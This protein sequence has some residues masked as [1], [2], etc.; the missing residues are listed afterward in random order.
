MFNLHFEELKLQILYRTIILSNQNHNSHH[1][2]LEGLMVIEIWRSKDTAA[3]FLI[4][5]RG[6]N[7]CIVPIRT[8]SHFGT[9][10]TKVAIGQT[11]V[12]V[13]TET[14]QKKE[15]ERERERDSSILTFSG[16]GLGPKFL[17][18]AKERAISFSFYPDSR[19]FPIERR[20]KRDFEFLEIL[21]FV[22]PSFSVRA[23]QPGNE[24][25]SEIHFER[26]PK[27]ATTVPARKKVFPRGLFVSPAKLD[28]S[29]F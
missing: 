25:R 5:H 4:L 7:P 28:L 10:A 6:S 19:E 20:I 2:W 12:N 16:S 14:I 11:I 24:K 1:E 15:R 22:I 3:S 27:T 13:L 18:T 8:F 23:R 26:E 29:K 21:A 17:L 9:K